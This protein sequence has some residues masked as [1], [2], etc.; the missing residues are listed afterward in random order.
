MELEKES[1]DLT[2]FMIPFGRFKFERTPFGLNCAPE[3]FQR[4]MVQIFGDIPGV[5][6][7]FDDIAI[8]A[9]DYVEHDEILA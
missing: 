3:M 7:Y 5:L 9:S 6:V 2:T 8:V 4:K 1:S